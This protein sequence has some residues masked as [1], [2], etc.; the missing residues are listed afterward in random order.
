MTTS[1]S[2]RNRQERQT[3]SPARVIQAIQAR[4]R[5]GLPVNPQCLHR[6]DSR[7]LAAGRRYFGSWSAALKAAHVP[8]PRRNIHKRHPRGHWTRER[9]I[10]AITHHAR[11]GDPLHA[12]AMQ[13]LNNRLVSA[14]TYHFGSWAEALRQAGF[15]ADAI[16]A[17]RRHSPDTVLEEIRL[18]MARGA[19]LRDSAMRRHNRSLYNAAQTHFGSWRKAVGAA[20]MPDYEDMEQSS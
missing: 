9:L 15:D 3:W 2:T 11:E 12:H 5:A 7:L 17:T 20:Q 4:H 1:V 8:V 13:R 6:D 16:R 10:H 19:D 14:A 18:M